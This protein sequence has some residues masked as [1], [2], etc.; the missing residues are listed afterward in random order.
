[1]PENPPGVSRDLQRLESLDPEVK[2]NINRQSH[3]SG[4]SGAGSG[5]ELSHRAKSKMPEKFRLKELTTHELSMVF[6][7]YTGFQI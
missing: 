3:K 6:V 2:S 5:V 4:A 7:I 1:M